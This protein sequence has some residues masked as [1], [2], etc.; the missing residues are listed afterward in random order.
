MAAFQKSL[1]DL[2]ISA[3]VTTF[4]ASEFGRTLVSNGRGTDH[5][6]GGNTI[7]MGGAVAGGKIYGNFPEALITGD[8]LDVGKNGR[9]LPTTPNDLYFADLLT[10]YGLTDSQLHQSLPN[11]QN[12]Q[13]PGAFDQ[14]LS[15]TKT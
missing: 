10:W 12:F 4:T 14:R 1:D 11:L 7:I 13:S 6:W 2:G 3:N 9:L 5:G 15:I 8:G